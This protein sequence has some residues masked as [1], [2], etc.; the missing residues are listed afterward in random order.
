MLEFQNVV[1]QRG[2]KVLLDGA[3][4]RIERDQRVGF[5]GRNGAGKSSLLSVV[6]GQ[7]QEDA[8]HIQCDIQHKRI[9][10]LEQ[11]L[12]DSTLKVIDFVKSGDR[13]WHEV[14]LQLEKAEADLDGVKIA[15]AHARLQDIDG[16]TIDARAAIIL[17]GLGFSNAEFSKKVGEFSG[18]WQ[19]RLQLAKVLLSR[20]DLF[21]LDEPTNHLDLE[22]IAWLEKWIL[23][24]T[25]SVILISHD[26]GFL[27]N[28]C[29]QI[30][31]IAQQKLKVYAGNYTDFTRQFELQLE[32]ESRQRDKIIRQKAH[33]QKFVDRFRYKASKA[34]QAQSRMKAIEK[35]TM[36]PGMQ[37]ENPFHFSFLP[38]QKLSSPILK[39]EGNAG[40]PEKQVLTDINLS[41][42]ADDR[43]A[44]LGIN[45][46]GKSTF[47]KTLAGELALLKGELV[48]HTKINIGYYSQQQLDSLDYDSTP[49][50]HLLKDNPRI[51]ESQAR[52]FLGGFAF[53]GDRIFDK[54]CS[55]SGGEKARLA[56]AL[57]IFKAPNVLL[58]DEP[59][60]HLDI[61]MREA[62]IFAL[63]T[64]DGAVILISHDRY[65][66]NS[67]VDRLWLVEDGRV[68][69][70]K[71]N[72]DDYQAQV[73]ETADIP[74]P[75]TS[76]Q[77]VSQPKR[78][79]TKSKNL[80]RIAKLEREIEK[81][82]QQKEKL[83]QQ[84]AESDIYLPENMDTL[85]ER[86]GQLNKVVLA[87]QDVE[88][89]WLD[90][91]S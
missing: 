66:V 80:Q 44:L 26:R 90:L 32:I 67:V 77:P 81:L 17:H 2:K 14:S 1:L 46:A 34:K 58:L 10:Y 47:V 8:G 70:F 37:Q 20:A 23:S 48:K 11:S 84:L 52:K 39:I 12:P 69:N 60:N 13:E 5:I 35:L 40:Y 45:G 51:A 63:Q 74:K 3:S 53:S 25:C 49:L 28:V 85:K 71:G 89:L 86:Q 83:E 7:T 19:M 61:Q 27:D 29:T 65:F 4:A 75:T 42:T 64:F 73:L 79:K 33:M 59:T 15:E 50:A 82:T 41:L 72:L 30:L 24:Q 76:N 6:I 88:M 56:L 36:A 62:L 38:C 9:A 68:H 78:S 54:V 91:Q 87:L 18:G 57:L 31:H 43:I 16:Y 55:F 21:L 22:T